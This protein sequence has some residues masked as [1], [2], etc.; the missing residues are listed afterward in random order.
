MS[1]ITAIIPALIVLDLIWWFSADRLLRKAGWKG[2]ARL[3]HSL[4]FAFQL[5]ALSAV[6]ASDNQSS[7]TTC[8]GS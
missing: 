7:G 4:F 1:I 6:I 5:A 8:P 2:R 3:L